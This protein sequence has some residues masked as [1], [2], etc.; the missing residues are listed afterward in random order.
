MSAKSPGSVKP[1]TL[2]SF[3]MRRVFTQGTSFVCGICR[4]AHAS[5]DDANSCLHQCWQT[6]LKDAPWIGQKR[7][8]K[9]EFHCI[10]CQR[11]YDSAEGAANC[12]ADCSSK[13]TITSHEAGVTLGPRA[14]RTFGKRL[15]IR[16]SLK[17]P[18]K[19][20]KSP[21]ETEAAAALA[22]VT[23]ENAADG[24]ASKD[25]PDTVQ[26]KDNK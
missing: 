5:A 15:P 7:L 10:Y 23:P 26:K 12:A 8:G 14:K 13:M 18:Y 24:G 3:M 21:T 11:T 6:V 19:I 16:V 22:S 25:A 9:L 17:I 4:K 20:V 1:R 2:R